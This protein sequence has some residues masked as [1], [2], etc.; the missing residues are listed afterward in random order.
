MTMVFAFSSIIALWWSLHIQL[1]IYLSTQKAHERS[2]T[3]HRATFAPSQ[4][5]VKATLKWAHPPL[6]RRSNRALPL[7]K[8]HRST[9]LRQNMC[10]Y[11]CMRADFEFKWERSSSRRKAAPALM[12]RS[13]CDLCH[14]CTF[15]VS[16]FKALPVSSGV[17]WPIP[18]ENFHSRFLLAHMNVDKSN[19]RNLE[20]RKLFLKK[21]KK[22]KKKILCAI[23][24]DRKL[25]LWFK[26][27]HSSGHRMRGVAPSYDGEEEICYCR[28]GS[29]AQVS[30][31]WTIRLQIWINLGLRSLADEGKYNKGKV[32]QS[33][34][35][36]CRPFVC[37]RILLLLAPGE[38]H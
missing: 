29:N 15:H 11:M 23:S 12:N 28:S 25:C 3:W 33:D 34:R 8:Q 18:T 30:E 24:F 32:G 37:T 36:I 38:C 5:A 35:L 14:P 9:S 17:L 20:W 26:P 10:T 6:V 4:V 19:G 16:S 21:K 31:K 27:P 13:R 22:K 1:Q 7:L 2:G